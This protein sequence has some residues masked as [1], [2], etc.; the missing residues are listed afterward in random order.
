MTDVRIYQVPAQP[1][2][3]PITVFVEQYE[4]GRGRVTLRC[5]ASAWTA[6]WGSHGSGPV[7]EFFCSCSIDYVTDNLVW[8][9]NGLFTS[10]KTEK[11]HR[12]YLGR[13][14]E[15]VQEF[16][17]SNPIPEVSA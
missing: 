5:Y 6:Y 14:V 16:L 3:D 10:R 13:I 2:L 8:G 4:P 15:A 11:N 1:G 17:R 9:L 7:E 12:L